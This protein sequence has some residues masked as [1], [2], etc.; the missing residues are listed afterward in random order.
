MQLHGVVAPLYPPNRPKAPNYLAQLIEA[1]PAKCDVGWHTPIR[2]E[3]LEVHR[4]IAWP[5]TQRGNRQVAAK[6]GNR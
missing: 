3:Q 6:N 1:D 2:E 4:V 5:T